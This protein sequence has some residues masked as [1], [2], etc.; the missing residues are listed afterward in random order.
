MRSFNHCFMV[1]L[2]AAVSAVAL[3][4]ACCGSAKVDGVLADAPSSELVVKLLDINRYEV[5]DT[6]E[7]GKDGRFSCRIPVE[8]GQPEFI[9]LFYKDTKVSSLLLD[10]GDRVHV[11][12]DTTGSYVVTGSEECERLASVEKELADFSANFSRLV[13]ELDAVEPDSREAAA[14]KRQMGDSYTAYYRSRLKYVMEN[15]YSLTVVPVFYQVIGAGLPVFA[16]ETDAIHF[17]NAADSLETVY[18]D[19]KYVKALKSEAK[20][21]SDLLEL[22]VRL[23]TAEPVNFPEIELADTDARKM[24]LSEVDAKVVM[25]HFWNPGESLQ[26]MFNLD[27][28]KPV[29]EDYHSKGFEIYQVALTADKAGWARTVRSQ[30]LDWINVCDV[31]GY[32]S[33]AARVYNVSKLPV[34]FIIADGELVD[35]KV[36]DEA[37]LRKLLDRLL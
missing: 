14:L 9:Y 16:Q 37:S 30:G 20:R 36:T 27:V 33:P 21:R 23:R 8:K 12:A 26:K 4:S 31:L 3:L 29:Y 11:E 15:P 25:L 19:S 10:R 35:F 2:A 34:S 1:R 17:R 22:S 7:V 28:L 5:L 6:L 18:P 13:S 24:K 32:G